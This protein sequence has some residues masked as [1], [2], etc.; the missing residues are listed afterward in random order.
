MINYEL[1]ILQKLFDSRLLVE[2]NLYQA[3]GENLI[4]TIFSPAGPKNENTGSFS[5]TGVEFSG[6]LILLENLSA[7]VNY[8]YI[9]M[10]E[11]LLAAPE[12][13]LNFSINYKWENFLV[14][15]SL[16][17][18]NNL[19]TQITPV[20]VKE[21]YT[22]LNTRLSYKINRYIDVFLKAENLIDEKY[23]INYGYPMPGFVTFGGINL[24]Y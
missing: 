24:H 17:H 16:Q 11:P 19:Y 21:N 23:Y 22:L 18:I 3:D 14:N 9:S 5:N 2:L 12:Q 13:Q 10:K 7:Q 6:N 15:L 4:R 8:S 1:G 20:S